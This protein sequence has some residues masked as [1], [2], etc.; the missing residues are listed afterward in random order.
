MTEIKDKVIT[1]DA[2]ELPYTII[3]AKHQPTKGA[4]VYIHGGGL[5]LERPMI[6]RHSISIS[7]RNITI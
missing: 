6:Y 7:L 2:F 1:K 4:I 5:M 3:K